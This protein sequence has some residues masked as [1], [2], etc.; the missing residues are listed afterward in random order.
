MRLH[1]SL[2]SVRLMFH[3][4]LSR[5]VYYKH[6]IRAQSLLYFKLTLNSNFKQLTLFE[7]VRRLRNVCHVLPGGA[8]TQVQ[9]SWS[10]DL[11]YS[12]TRKSRTWLVNTTE[13]PSDRCPCGQCL[14]T[15]FSWTTM[16]CCD[17][18]SELLTH[19]LGE[20]QPLGHISRGNKLSYTAVTCSFWLN[21]M[22]SQVDR[23][24]FF[25]V[26]HWIAYS[27]RKWIAIRL[28]KLCHDVRKE[29][30]LNVHPKD[31]I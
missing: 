21:H 11:M 3:L 8:C 7:A 9:N 17:M 28:P 18:C 1:V 6:K 15:T 5:I 10:I 27:H 23:I 31:W 24:S 26:K 29:E 25:A 4:K 22:Q 14:L 13:L 12:C 30:V 16:W 2:F 19:N 20:P